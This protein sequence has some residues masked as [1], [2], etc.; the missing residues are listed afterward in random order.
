MKHFGGRVAVITGAAGGFGKEFARTGARLGMKL[1]L[2]DVETNALDQIAD[3]LRSSGVEVIA[4]VC[5]VRHARSLQ[6]LADAAMARFGVVHLL[7]NNAGVGS[8]GLIWESSEADW[9][10]ILSV[11]LRGVIHG[12]RIFTPLMLEAARRDAAY[13]GHIVNTA[14]IAGLV[15]APLMGAYNVSKH[16][17]VSLSETLYHDLNLV[18]QAVSASVLCPYFVPTGIGQSQRN[19]P[20][21]LPGAQTPTASQLLSQSMIDRAVSSGA[22]SPAQIAEWSFDAVREK[23]FYICPHAD[24]MQVVRTRMEDV[25]L[26]R[27]PTDPYAAMPKIREMLTAKLATRT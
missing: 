17:I 1:V 21:D 3:E 14:S 27:N 22:L 12:V 16:A 4:Q 25:M 26:E 9:E 24:G 7:F 5:D 18:G 20:S 8:S 19:R 6:T 10:W 2:A 13:E 11:N 15:N 23:R